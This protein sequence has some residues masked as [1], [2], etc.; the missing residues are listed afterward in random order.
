MDGYSIGY[1][2][3]FLASL[4]HIACNITYEIASK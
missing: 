1:V 4:M 2:K 3:S